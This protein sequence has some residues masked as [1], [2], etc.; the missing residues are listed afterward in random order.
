VLFLG[1]SRITPTLFF[2][3]SFR[4]RLIFHV[5]RSILESLSLNPTCPY[6]RL[7]FCS[8]IR[9][10]TSSSMVTSIF[11]LLCRIPDLLASPDPDPLMFETNWIVFTNCGPSRSPIS[12]PRDFLPNHSAVRHV[13]SLR[14]ARPRFLLGGGDRLQNPLCSNISLVFTPLRLSDT[15][16]ASMDSCEP[17]ECGTTDLEYRTSQS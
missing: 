16:R 3:L 7:I 9:L 5:L 10:R 1:I 12:P 13:S 4:K 6:F 17:S 11:L 14:V 8:R 15:S 2:F